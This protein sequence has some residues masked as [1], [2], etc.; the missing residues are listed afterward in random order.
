MLARIKA[1][2]TGD[3]TAAA[4]ASGAT[5]ERAA[6]AVALFVESALLDGDF[7]VAERRTIVA[8][9]VERFALLAEDADA[10]IDAAL[11]TPDH[12]NRVFAAS[13]VIR[14]GFTEDERVDV[15]EM[16]WQVV[17]ADGELHDYEANLVRRIAGLLYVK[18]QDSGRARKRALRRLGLDDTE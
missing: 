18:D 4:P 2:L 17:Y 7:D 13:R 6:A 8:I 11:A 1:F 16:L 12:A 10:L 15:L 14:D 5:D 9:L 3:E